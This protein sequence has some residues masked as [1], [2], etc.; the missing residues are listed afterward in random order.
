MSELSKKYKE[1]IGDIEKHIT[2]KEQ[3][4]Y[5]KGQIAEISLL[6]MDIIDRLSEISDV[7]IQQMEQKQREIDSKISKVQAMVDGIENDIYEENGYEFEINCPYCNFE[8]SVEL[9]TELKDE[10]QCPECHNLIELDWN[11]EEVENCGGHC[12]GCEGCGE[13][14]NESQ[15]NKPE[16]AEKDEKPEEDDM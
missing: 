9:D 5:I 8:F 6:F 4:E 12:S 15:D 10:I 3:L 16:T 2:D 1:T 11:A 13:E 14:T 7:R